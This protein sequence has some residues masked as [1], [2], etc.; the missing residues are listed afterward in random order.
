MC[1]RERAWGGREGR[2]RES[3]THRLTLPPYPSLQPCREKRTWGRGLPVQ[4]E[5]GRKADRQIVGRGRT[6]W[7]KGRR[8]KNSRETRRQRDW[9]FWG[10]DKQYLAVVS[11]C[12]CRGP[13]FRSSYLRAGVSPWHMAARSLGPELE[14]EIIEG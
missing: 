5:A 4:R 2:E 3:H 1:V 12:S 14:L 10:R 9:D 8:G 6:D 13:H 7:A 11:A